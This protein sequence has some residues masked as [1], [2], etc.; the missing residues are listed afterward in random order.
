MFKILFQHVNN[1]KKLRM[2]YFI[3]F[4]HSKASKSVVDFTCVG[5]LNSG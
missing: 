5:H 1:V 2:R 3:F 4:L